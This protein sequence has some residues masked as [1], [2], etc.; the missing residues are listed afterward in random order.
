M[1]FKSRLIR[2]CGA[3]VIILCD[4]IGP[5]RGATEPGYV[6]LAVEGDGV[7][8]KVEFDTKSNDR[9]GNMVEFG[10]LG[11]ELLLK[12]LEEHNDDK[13]RL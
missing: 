12:V 4:G 3:D 5:T 9:A 13:G 10:R 6:A 11:L 7:Q 1:K 2:N 8:K